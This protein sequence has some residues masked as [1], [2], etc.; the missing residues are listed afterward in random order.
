MNHNNY[1]DNQLLLNNS[2][3]GLLGSIYLDDWFDVL[4]VNNDS[5]LILKGLNYWSE[6]KYICKAT[7]G[8]DEIITGISFFFFF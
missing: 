7:F 8:S 2:N 4:I 5:E 3:N 1:R 6:K